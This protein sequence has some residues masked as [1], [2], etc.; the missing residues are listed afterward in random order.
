MGRVIVGT[1]WLGT[2]MI[3][4]TRMTSIHIGPTGIVHLAISINYYYEIF[5]PK[6]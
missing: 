2:H 6:K 5:P 1:V 4:G 3:V